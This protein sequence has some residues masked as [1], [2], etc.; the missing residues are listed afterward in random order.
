[1]TPDGQIFVLGGKYKCSYTRCNLEL[2]LDVQLNQHPQGQQLLTSKKLPI[3]FRYMKNV[4]HYFILPRR[5]LMSEKAGFGHCTTK[6]E[7]YIAG[8]QD[9][10]Y[11]E[12]A[13]V[14]SYDIKRD[15]WKNLPGM[16]AARYL[17]S[18]TLFRQR[19]LYV[20]GGQNHSLTTKNE[21]PAKYVKEIERLDVREGAQW[22]VISVK[23][24]GEDS[25][26]EKIQGHSLS[27]LQIS[28]TEILI[29]GSYFKR[30][31]PVFGEI[32]FF[33]FD[34]DK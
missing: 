10:R 17:P 16:K 11:S 14:E 33:L 6:N 28:A 15:A 4:G 24:A 21:R 27:S 20:F 5:D 32:L 8:G 30:T 1:V 29:F 18:I 19:F 2:V 23:G 22:E 13:K 7:I 26:I 12:L 31:A 34:H 3:A 25:L 9:G